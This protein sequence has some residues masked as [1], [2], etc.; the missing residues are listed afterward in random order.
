MTINERIDNDI[1]EAMKSGQKERLT[2]LRGLKSDLKYKIID[3][4]APLSDEESVA[5]LMS[6]AK[7]VKDSIDQ[8]RAGGRTDLVEHEEFG[9]KIIQGYLPEQMSEEKLREII[10]ATIAEIGADSVAKVGLVMKAVV[11]K[12]KG[13]A[14]GKLVNKIALELLAK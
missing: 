8:F 4:G 12:V 9:L 1:K 5:V 13:Q 11:P 14:D 7:K 10:Q 6:N 3:K 2:V